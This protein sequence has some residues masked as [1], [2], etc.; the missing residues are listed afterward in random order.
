MFSY[1]IWPTV[2]KSFWAPT[3]EFRMITSGSAWNP[4]YP[5]FLRAFLFIVLIVMTLQFALLVINRLR[6]K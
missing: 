1:S 5:T 2:V 3:G 4:P 6:G